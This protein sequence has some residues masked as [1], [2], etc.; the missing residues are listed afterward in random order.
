MHEM[1]EETEYICGYS[2]R[3]AYNWHRHRGMVVDIG[4]TRPET[5]IDGFS[6]G[7]FSA[8]P[9]SVDPCRLYAAQPPWTMESSSLRSIDLAEHVAVVGREGLE[10]WLR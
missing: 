5:Q 7:N 8:E 3:L 6:A 10:S 4:V 9:Y 1:G 2:D